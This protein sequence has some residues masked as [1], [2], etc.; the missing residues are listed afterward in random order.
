MEQERDNTM[1]ES[2][3]E[4]EKK[5]RLGLGGP[6]F[7]RNAGRHRHHHYCSLQARG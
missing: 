7:T 1:G 4:Q 2:R 5:A 3:R 6:P